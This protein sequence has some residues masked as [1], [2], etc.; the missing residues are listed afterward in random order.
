LR[1]A[2]SAGASDAEIAEAIFVAMA[3]R[4]GGSFAHAAIAMG[5]L[6]SEHKTTP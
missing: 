3:P 2:K 1:R 6:E 4:A 5:S